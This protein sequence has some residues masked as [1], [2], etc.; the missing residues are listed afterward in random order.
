[1][2]PHDVGSLPDEKGASW[3]RVAVACW[4]ITDRDVREKCRFEQAPRD[5]SRLLETRS[6]IKNK[7]DDARCSYDESEVGSEAKN[8]M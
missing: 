8:K 5:A 2:R 6:R 4:A 7:R 1:M 3:A